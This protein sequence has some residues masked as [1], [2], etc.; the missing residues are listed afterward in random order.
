MHLGRGGLNDPLYSPGSSYG[1]VMLRAK[2]ACWDVSVCF[3]E[4]TVNMVKLKKT[5]YRLFVHLFKIK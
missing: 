3:R 5:H 4:A 2:L 1:Q